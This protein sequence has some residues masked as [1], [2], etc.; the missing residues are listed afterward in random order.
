MSVSP[1]GPENNESFNEN[2]VQVD[3]LIDLP[4][5]PGKVNSREANYMLNDNKQVKG[6]VQDAK[7][8]DY[9]VEYNNNEE[10]ATIQCSSGFYKTVARPCFASLSVNSI[11]SCM[12]VT[13]K[14]TNITPTYDKNKYEVVALIHFM[15]AIGQ[16]NLG[17]IAVHLYHSARKIQIQGSAVMP[18]TTKIVKWFTSNFVLTKFKEQAKLKKYLINQTNDQIIASSR[19]SNTNPP[20]QTGQNKCLNSSMFR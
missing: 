9:E 20:Q 19:S 2:F 6:I 7:L 3:G 10:N 14:V 17:I 16:E 8:I 5:S 12:D 18:D 15:L 11:L 1:T 4:L 13:I